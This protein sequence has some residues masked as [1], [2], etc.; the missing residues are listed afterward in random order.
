MCSYFCGIR[1]ST[2]IA[3][4]AV[5]ACKL[6][7]AMCGF[8]S[9]VELGLIP[10]FTVYQFYVSSQ[11]FRFLLCGMGIIPPPGV[12]VASMQG[13]LCCPSLFFFLHIHIVN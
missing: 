10:S 6:G 11:S 8:G 2:L 4:D 12:V 5:I 13:S 7:K 9:P 3:A 1:F